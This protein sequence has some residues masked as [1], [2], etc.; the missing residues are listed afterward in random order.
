MRLAAITALLA[1][2]A[3]CRSTP[4]PANKEGYPPVAAQR[5]GPYTL[6]PDDGVTISVWRHEDL[7]IQT[8]VD[9]AG[10]IQMPLIGDVRAVGLTPSQLADGIAT[11]LS[12]YV[13]NPRV[14]VAISELGSRQIFVLG[15][16]VNPGAI[17]MSSGMS[18][19]EAIARAG[20]FTSDAKRSKVALVRV[21]DKQESV[22]YLLNLDSLTSS[23]G[24]RYGLNSRD[25]LYVPST[26]LAKVENF[27]GRLN[28][29]LQPFLTTASGI[30]VGKEA[31]DV[32][33]SKDA[34]SS[35]ASTS[36][37]PISSGPIAVTPTR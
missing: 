30:V 34:D 4:E 29:I 12:R 3:S 15:E 1:I 20:G 27:M 23:S 10:N 13:K 28:T 31:A 6:E 18:T 11:A 37:A 32:L 7:D 35:S 16:V 36:I 2:G 19:M 24:A 9:P 33:Q 8:V 5:T 21:N 26:T 22:A 14:N 25:I 17:K